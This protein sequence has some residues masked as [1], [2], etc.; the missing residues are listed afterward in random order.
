VNPMVAIAVGALLA[1]EVITPRVLA[2]A[3]VIVSSVVLIN[4]GEHKKTQVVPDPAEIEQA[5]RAE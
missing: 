4:L 3:I 1:G 2:A 5:G